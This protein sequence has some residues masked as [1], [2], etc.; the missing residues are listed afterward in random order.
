MTDG[1]LLLLARPDDAA[2]GPLQQQA[3]RRL[4]HATIEDL[5]RAGWRYESGCPARASACAGGR[6]MSAEHIAAVVCRITAVTPRDL[7]QLHRDDRAYVAAE[8][9]AFLRAWLAQFEGIRFNE[10]TWVS[11]AGPAWHPLQWTWLVARTGVPVVS[12][13]PAD[14]RSECD[15]ATAT[16]VRGDVFGLTDPL[17]IDYSLRI[18]RAARAGLLDVTF[19]HDGNWKFLSADPCPQLDSASAAALVRHSF[20]RQSGP[21]TTRSAGTSCGVA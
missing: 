9:N 14:A 16:V 17:L 12:S 18:A 6:V 10:A 7:P 4:A 21:P 13:P 19:V 5:S 15:T 3:P 2:V 8:M 11:L 20:G 1:S